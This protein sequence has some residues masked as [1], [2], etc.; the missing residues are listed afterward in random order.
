ML[1][2]AGVLEGQHHRLAIVTRGSRSTAGHHEEGSQHTP[3]RHRQIRDGQ[4]VR[5]P[6]A[7]TK[8]AGPWTPSSGAHSSLSNP[9]LAHDTQG[10]QPLAPAGAQRTATPGSHQPPEPSP[11]RA[12][13]ATAT[14]S[15]H[16]SAQAT[17]TTLG[18]TSS[19]QN[20]HNGT[21]SAQHSGPEGH[22]LLRT[23]NAA[24]RSGGGPWLQKISIEPGIRAAFVREA[25]GS[26]KSC[27]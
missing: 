9:A 23:S 24:G 26:G 13:G 14:R 5:L 11:A 1:T 18:S 4:A 10:G 15:Q 21:T 25:N 16:A 22:Q 27:V 12:Y 2:Q 3:Q 6:A 17:A 7:S 8:H 19:R 20:L